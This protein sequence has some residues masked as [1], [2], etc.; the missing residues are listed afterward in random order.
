MVAD[1]SASRAA[2][3]CVRSSST[4]PAVLPVRSQ[5]SASWRVRGLV[6]RDRRPSTSR[7]TA[8][9]S[10]LAAGRA[11][12]A[13][14]EH[15]PQLVAL[16]R[17]LQAVERL[18]DHAL[19]LVDRRRAAGRCR[20]A[21]ARPRARSADAPTA[22]RRAWRP[23]SDRRP[24]RRQLG[25]LAAEREH[26]R[27]GHRFAGLFEPAHRAG[28]VAGIL[29]PLGQPQAAPSPPRRARRSAPGR[30]RRRAA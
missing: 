24:R 26:R 25:H 14:G 9:A 13:V 11:E 10:S 29:A 27:R 6:L 21:A 17:L 23:A 4:S 19:E 18:R 1:R 5:C 28:D 20:P 15:H 22:A 3:N 30:S 2:A 8:T 16:R 7:S 12:Q